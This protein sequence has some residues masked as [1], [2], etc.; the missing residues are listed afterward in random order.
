MLETTEAIS[1]SVVLYGV[2][3]IKRTQTVG[4]ENSV[5][6]RMFGPKGKEV[7]AGGW[8][9]LCNE[10]IH[11][12]YSSPNIILGWGVRVPAGAGNFSLHHHVQTG[13]GANPA[14]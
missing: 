10:D 1:N 14:S 5:L 9:K 11:N 13:S 8:R 3:H 4:D 7:V 6:R 12:I 2:S